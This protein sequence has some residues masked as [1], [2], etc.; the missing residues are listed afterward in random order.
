M[1]RLRSFRR[2]AV[3]N[4]H[5]RFRIAAGAID[6]RSVEVALRPGEGASVTFLGV[7]R[8]HGR[9]GGAVAGLSYEAYEPM[10]CA[11]F[12]LIEAEARARFGDIRLSIVH[13]VGDLAVGEV[14]VAV[15][16][17]AA[18][19]SAAFDA[20]RYAIDQLKRRAPIWKKERYAGGDS[21]WIANESDG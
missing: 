15:S 9:D 14:A 12:E 21:S 5:A 3:D 6:P 11:E 19:R 8:D 2:W 13:A 17:V 16:A 4:T 7:V 10:A 20:C 1:T 18:H